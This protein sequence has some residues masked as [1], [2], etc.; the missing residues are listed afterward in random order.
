MQ[1]VQFFSKK[2]VR[3]VHISTENYTAYYEQ[4]FFLCSGVNLPNLLSHS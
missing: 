2:Y 3:V 1:T 4:L